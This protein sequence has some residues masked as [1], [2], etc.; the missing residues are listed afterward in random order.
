VWTLFPRPVNGAE[1]VFVRDPKADSLRPVDPWGLLEHA[2]PLPS[3]NLVAASD[4]VQ[5][6]RRRVFGCV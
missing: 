4:V 6:R 5:P 1:A 2:A 3:D